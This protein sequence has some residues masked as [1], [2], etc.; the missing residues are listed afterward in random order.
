MGCVEL[1][2]PVA[3]I[4]YLK[5]KPSKIALLLNLDI[6]IIDRIVYNE[7]FIVTDPSEDGELGYR[8]TLTFMQ[9]QDFVAKC[10]KSK[11]K[12]STGA[13]AIKKLLEDL[14]LEK[15][16]NN[17]RHLLPTARPN[18]RLDLIK[19]LRLINQFLG[20][21][22]SPTWMI[23]D[24]LPILPPELRPLVKLEEGFFV[25]SDLNE[26]Y[27]RILYRCQRYE[28]MVEGGM[29]ET[30]LYNDRRLIQEAVDCLMQNGANGKPHND[31]QGRPLKSLA[32]IIKGKEG[33]FRRNLLG[34]RVDYSGRSVIV[35]GG[36]GLGTC[37]LPRDMAVILFEPFIIY[38]V[39]CRGW[40]KTV[41]GARKI[42]RGWYRLPGAKQVEFWEVVGRYVEGHPIIVNRAP[43][44]HKF[45][46]QAFLPFLVGGSGICLPPSSCSAFNADFDGDQVA[47]HVP[48]S[49][50]AQMECMTIVGGV[51]PF[52]A[53]GGLSYKPGQDGIL[54]SFYLTCDFHGRDGAKKRYFNDLKEVTTAHEQGGVTIQDSI[55]LRLPPDGSISVY[56]EGSTDD[57]G[58][59]KVFIEK[60]YKDRVYLVSADTKIKLDSSGTVRETYILTTVGRVVFNVKLSGSM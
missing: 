42:V 25:S 30:I 48:L 8:S 21:N 38:L 54:G 22:S 6:K 1:P 17:L 47:V 52:R 28:S 3:H 34:K 16:A 40:A 32:D 20:T 39:V 35:S 43:S 59:N 56:S 13:V 36:T 15:E 50:S 29:P 11:V 9:W 46:L 23:L 44:L 18:V 10:P 31:G 57:H 51:L 7:L 33:R 49:L 14:D 5:A 41:I 26:L 53:D 4:W 2:T 12:I 19:R 27:K 37:G 58:E 55:W 24:V 60:A 45:S